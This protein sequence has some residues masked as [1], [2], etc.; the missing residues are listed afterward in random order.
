M[1]ARYLKVETKG[2][3]GLKEDSPMAVYS[4]DFGHKDT[5]AE[6]SF[7]VTG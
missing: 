1:R 5:K 4:P 6:D 3:T 2:L 7:A